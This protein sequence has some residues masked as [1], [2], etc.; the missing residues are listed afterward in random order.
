MV[1]LSNYKAVILAG[2]KG[3]RLYPVTF[4]IP[5]PLLPVGRKPILNY[6]VD[7]FLSQGVKDI[8]V[9][10]SQSFREDFDWWKKRYY[11]EHTITFFQ[12]KEA[13]GTFG[14]LSLAKDW[15]GD[16]HVFL[17]NG[18]DLMDVNLSAM[19][20]FHTR[21]N[22]M[23]TIALVEVPNPQGYGVVV[24][25]SEYVKEF[26]EKPENPPTNYISSGLYLL[27]P[28]IFTIHPGPT[29]TMIETDI[30]PKLA[31]EK[32]LTGFQFQGRWIDTGT[33][34]RYQKAIEEWK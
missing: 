2:G 16:R 24:C 19:A 22:P 30:F 7:L 32:K 21:L 23:A 8:A 28:E 10:I 27:S 31:R 6:V 33:W 9:L 17:I 34:E 5:K 26:I 12:E 11:P 20:E 18:D 3:T 14:G 4:E 13:L 29:F 1:S 25:E 15:I